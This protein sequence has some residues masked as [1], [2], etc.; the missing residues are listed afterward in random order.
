MI[1][2]KNILGSNVITQI[3][4]VV[5]DIDKSAAEYADFF[6]VKKPGISITGPVEETHGEYNGKPLEGKAK[7]AFFRFKNITIELIEPV[8]GPS[9]WQEYLNA[10]GEG[11]HHIAL[12]VRDSKGKVEALDKKGIP[13]IQRGDFKGGDYSYLDASGPLKVIIELLGHD[14]KKL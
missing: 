2:K 4:I 3:G 14:V 10:H 13:L 12:N 9:T 11:V 1:G 5:R 8:D 7:L 6:G